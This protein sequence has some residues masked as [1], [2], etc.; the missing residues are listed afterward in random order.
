MKKFK[1]IGIIFLLTVLTCGV[2]LVPQLVSKQYEKEL[3]SKTV[4]RSY[5]AGNRPK[6]TC[7]Q[8]ARLYRDRE[9]NVD[10]NSQPVI[11][12][13]SPSASGQSGDLK[14]IRDDVIYLIDILFGKDKSVSDPLKEILT[15]GKVS[16]YRNGKLIKIDNRPTALNFV[17]CNVI[18][19]A[20]SFQIIYEEKT[21]TLIRLSCDIDGANFKNKSDRELYRENVAAMTKKYFEEQLK[22]ESGEYFFTADVLPYEAEDEDESV[23]NG[24]PANII[25]GCE[26]MTDFDESIEE[27]DMQLNN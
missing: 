27:K 5:N 9:V 8:V 14:A 22:L 2:V 18:N 25:I 20:N 4:Y 12:G 17:S 13:S 15:E 6:V 1:N 11:N 23:S 7:E 19:G 26:I 21:K 16:F 24:R 10:Y 3:L